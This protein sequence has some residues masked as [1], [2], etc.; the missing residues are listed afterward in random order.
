MITQQH[1]HEQELTNARNIIDEKQR[2]LT[3]TALR[4]A[5]LQDS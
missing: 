2:E 5:N 1:L 3:S 4:M